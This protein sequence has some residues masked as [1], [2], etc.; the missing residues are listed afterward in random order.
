[1]NEHD[2]DIV[3]RLRD[4]THAVSETI[5]HAPVP[6]WGESRGRKGDS[7]TWKRSWLVPVAAAAS[8]TVAVAGG[9]AIAQ[10]GGHAVNLSVPSTA[11]PPAAPKFFADARP[12]KIT[13]R[14]VSDGSVTNELS[15]PSGGE[16]FSGVQAAQDNRLFYVAAG[17]ADCRFRFYQFTLDD[18]G[19]IKSYGVLPFTPPE[20]T[21]PTSLAVNGD[22][23][24]LAYGLE[25]CG[26]ATTPGGLVITDTATG[27]SRTWKAKEGA[28]V[29]DVSVSADGR[30]VLFRR[31]PTLI[32]ASE[33]AVPQS[34]GELSATI[35]SGTSTD[36]APP[37]TGTADAVTAT[38]SALPTY[39]SEITLTATAPP[40]NSLEPTAPAG[41]SG[42]RSGP[43]SGPGSV[44]GSPVP[45]VSA[46]PSGNAGGS[47]ASGDPVPPSPAGPR[48]SG[49]PTAEPNTV[50]VDPRTGAV[51]SGVASAPGPQAT[52]GGGTGVG[53]RSPAEGPFGSSVTVFSMCPSSPFDPAVLP[54]GASTGASSAVPPVSQ[55]SVTIAP[56]ASVPPISEA[57]VPPTASA[58]PPTSAIPV[59][60]PASE[61]GNPAVTAESVLTCAD[62]QEVSLLDT[63][64]S[65]D[66]IDQARTF[67]LPASYDGVSGGVFGVAISPDG[68][69]I[70]ASVGHLGVRIVDGTA[71]PLPGSAGVIAY[72]T[73]DGKPLAVVYK[74]ADKGA[75]RQLDLDGTGQS[76]ITTRNGEIGAIEGS[77]YRTVVKAAAADTM[78]YP[79]MIA[80]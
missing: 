74:D 3:N 46:A 78:V 18:D 58:V 24:K 21:R 76:V 80:W 55:P 79:S 32:P 52:D 75:M 31:G 42:G 34:P 65:G 38:F 27:D 19:K 12:D 20:G 4:A 7:R 29:R 49:P 40:A 28:G 16:L 9:A 37:T 50:T 36:G 48:P 26:S 73:A 6:R 71:R 77:G 53:G 23:S 10:R 14:N 69:R 13:I 43:G 47:A 15:H 54:P 39:Q 63:T 25:P 61:P 44:P 33:P 8:V 67:T 56:S 66:G 62:S 64:T 68:T 17:T 70:L 22:G 41:E 45:G 11:G 60:P 57:P 59:R 30:Y 1:M 2:E 51:V 35:L 72:G 5:D